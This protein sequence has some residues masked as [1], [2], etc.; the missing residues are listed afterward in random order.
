MVS[1]RTLS[2][3]KRNSDFHLTKGEKPT[4]AANILGYIKN[5]NN[6]KISSMS[7]TWKEI[8]KFP[9]YEVS[10]HG[11]IRNI[12]TK[13]PLRSVPH[14]LNSEPTI[15]MSGYCQR[16]RHYVSHVVLGEFKYGGMYYLR[17]FKV[18]HKDG[19][20]SNNN[21]SN[22]EVIPQKATLGKEKF[23]LYP[24]GETVKVE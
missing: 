15:K 1:Q 19:N 11:N 5:T 2:R 24:N 17:G 12:K 4:Q 6:K 13:R 9:K 10:D 23:L 20:V 18:R 16:E 7:E 3:R 22:L 21:L 14:S 8:E